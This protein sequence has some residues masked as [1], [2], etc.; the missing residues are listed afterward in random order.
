M[1]FILMLLFLLIVSVIAGVIRVLRGGALL[2]EP[3]P[4]EPHMIF[5]KKQGRWWRYDPQNKILED[6][7]K[8]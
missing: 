8:R 1:K 2:P 6:A 7:F 5:D 4:G 3:G